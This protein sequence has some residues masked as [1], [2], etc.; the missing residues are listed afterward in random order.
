MATFGYV[1]TV[2]TQH[3]MADNHFDGSVFTS[4]DDIAGATIS[5]ITGQVSSGTPH[6]YAKAI[7]V[8]HSTLAIVPNGVSSAVEITEA[9]FGKM[10]FPFPVSPSL[11]NS[12]EYIL[13]IVAG[14]GQTVYFA[15]DTG[16]TNQ[17]HAEDDNNYTTPTNLSSVTHS[18]RRFSIYATYT[19]AGATGPTGP[20]PTHKRV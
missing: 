19:T 6:G 18:T 3:S 13:G 14:G 4:P 2:Y 7:I 11:S 1:A 12:T 15:L 17:S 10:D 9:G 8:L 16:A 20:F 5:K